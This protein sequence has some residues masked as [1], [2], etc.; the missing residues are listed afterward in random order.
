MVA[1]KIIEIFKKEVVFVKIS[2][3]MMALVFTLVMSSAFS[4]SAFAASTKTVPEPL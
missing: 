2:K 1:S 3:F 4:N